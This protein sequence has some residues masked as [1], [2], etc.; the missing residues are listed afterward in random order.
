MALAHGVSE[1]ALLEDLPEL[2]R[3]DIRAAL[4]WAGL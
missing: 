2:E 1:D 3:D 4:L